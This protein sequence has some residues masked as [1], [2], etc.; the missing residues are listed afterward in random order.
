MEFRMDLTPRGYDVTKPE[1]D[2]LSF[3]ISIYDADWRWP[4]QAQKFS[5][6]R[7]WW[8]GPFSAF[9]SNT[10]RIHA[11]PDVT[12]S[13]G[14]VPEVEPELIVPSAEHY[15]APDIDGSLNETVWANAPSF[16]VRYGDDAL[17]ATYPSIGPIASGQFQPE[18]GG[19][20]AAVL[21]PGDAT[22]KYFFKGDKLYVGVDVRDQGVWSIDT[23]AQWDGI[24]FMINDRV[25]REPLNHDLLGRELIVRFN[26]SGQ[27]ITGGY[28][29]DLLAVNGAEVGV[30]IKPNTTINNFDDVDEGYFIEL[31]VDLTKLGYPAGRGDGIIFLGALLFDG[32]NR[33]NPVDSYGNWT[34]WFKE[35]GGSASPVWAYMDPNALVT[36]VKDRNNNGIP[37]DFA[38]VGNYPNPFNPTTT[39]RYTMPEPGLVTLKVYDLLGRNVA[40]IPLGLQQPGYKVETK[41]NASSLSTGIYLYRLQMVSAATKKTLSTVYGKMMIVK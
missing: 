16:D 41:F 21:D 38:I 19:G 29:N 22:F 5:G 20:R 9:L 30:S 24:R 25:A 23:D 13:S 31:A 12:V 35:R 40:D 36:S 39:I 18:V 7:T 17:R 2:I 6:N 26:P 27:V 1:G 11:R 15:N 8:Q 32:E 28:L 4:L 34:W 3:N 37:K 14:P 33:P 10:V